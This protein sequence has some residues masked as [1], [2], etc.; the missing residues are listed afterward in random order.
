MCAALWIG[1]AECVRMSVMSRPVHAITPKAAALA[2]AALAVALSLP[3]P[4]SAAPERRSAILPA[5]LALGSDMLPVTRRK[6]F[7]IPKHS[8]DQVLVFAP[9]AVDDYRAGWTK[10]RSHSSRRGDVESQ[11][12]EAKRSFSFALHGGTAPVEAS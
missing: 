6:T 8:T 10:S 1:G 9:F 3:A 2:T 12:A 4:A 5:E 7:L 11:H